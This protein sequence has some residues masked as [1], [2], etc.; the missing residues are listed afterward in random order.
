MRV[1]AVARWSY[2]QCITAGPARMDAVFLPP[3]ADSSI[4]DSPTWTFV[5]LAISVALLNP[6][7]AAFPG[8]PRDRLVTA[9]GWAE[10]G[11]AG[12]I[13]W[14]CRIPPEMER[15]Q[16]GALG[17]ASSGTKAGRGTTTSVDSNYEPRS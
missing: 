6:R 3:V 17:S 2:G 14:G 12:G 13:R 1:H 15:Q 16:M 8:K 11:E 4:D 7:L 5:S 9:A 10:R